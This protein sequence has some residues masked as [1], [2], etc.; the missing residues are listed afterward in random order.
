MTK[1]KLYASIVSMSFKVNTPEQPI[2]PDP[3]AIVGRNQLLW[4]NTKE[5]LKGRFKYIKENLSDQSGEVSN[6]VMA[7]MFAGSVAIAGWAAVE[8]GA[9]DDSS[10]F[11]EGEGVER[12]HSGDT[13]FEIAEQIEADLNLG[14][15]IRDIAYQLEKRNGYSAGALPVGKD[16]IV[17]LA[18][19]E[20]LEKQG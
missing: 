3:E 6:K 13:Y 9:F 19:D 12:I 17:P 2:T 14:L 8:N 16:M 20:S 10:I 1:L 7:V 4:S 18:P 11:D 5:W 15:D